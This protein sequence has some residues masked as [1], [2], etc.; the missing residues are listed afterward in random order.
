MSRGMPDTKRAPWAPSMISPAIFL[1][2][3]VPIRRA[4]AF[5]F[6]RN[7]RLGVSEAAFLHPNG[8]AVGSD[9]GVKRTALQPVYAS[10]PPPAIIYLFL[11]VYNAAF[12]VV[13]VAIARERMLWCDELITHYIG[14]LPGFSDVWS[15]LLTGGDG[16]PPLYYAIV[17]SSLAVFGVSDLSLRLPSML[18][19]V[20]ASLCLFRFVSLR[21][22]AAYGVLAASFLGISGYFYYA[23]E[24]RS[25]ALVLGFSA[26]ALCCW[27]AAAEHRRRVASILGLWLA[28]AAA[29]GCHYYAV[30]VLFPLALGE[31][32]RT[33]RTRRIDVWVWGA[34]VG[35]LLPLVFVLP[36]VEALAKLSADFLSPPTWRALMSFW[37]PICLGAAAGFLIIYGTIGVGRVLAIVGIVRPHRPAD[38]DNRSR[39]AITMPPHEFA[40]ALGFFLIPGAGFLLAIAATGAFIDRY[41]LPGVL[42]AAILFAVGAYQ[43]VKF[44]FRVLVIAATCLFFVFL[45]IERVQFLMASMERDSFQSVVAMLQ[46]AETTDELPIVVNEVSEFM[47]LWHYGPPELA[48]RL[49]YLVDPPEARAFR[50]SLNT[51]V[52]MRDMVGSHFHAKVEEFGTF[53]VS[54]QRFF[55]YAGRNG[56][57]WLESAL[58]WDRFNY[59]LVSRVDGGLPLFIADR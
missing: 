31:A 33:A 43:V 20:V 19:F 26:L 12:V 55:L 57:R 53:V 47:Q 42:G 49:V 46:S 45:G 59:R 34:L 44:R 24:A 32:V 30:L 25:Y 18:G 54:H 35:A 9:P 37:I 40:A 16:T 2:A 41:V 15:A 21:L 39:F 13:A 38:P 28:L 50:G 23:T 27:Q 7:G 8:A 58:A 10:E 6:R 48:S 5:L 1:N 4:A 36:H 3:M 22:P 17:R 56:E 29:I 14:T 52:V 51:E 11:L